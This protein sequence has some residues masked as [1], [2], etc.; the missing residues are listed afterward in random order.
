MS[1]VSSL[2]PRL[3][4]VLAFYDVPGNIQA[5]KTEGAPNQ[6]ISPNRPLW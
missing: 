1:L 6:P 4:G 3:V 2:K 5:Q